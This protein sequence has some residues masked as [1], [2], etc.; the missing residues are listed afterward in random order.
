MGNVHGRQLENTDTTFHQGLI[1]TQG[2]PK[3]T[4]LICGATTDI[5]VIA[6]L[7]VLPL[8]ESATVRR[9]GLLKRMLDSKSA[10]LLG[11]IITSWD[12]QRRWA[13]KINKDL[14]I[15]LAL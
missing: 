14:Q 12:Q 9:L 13:T 5:G 1:I 7:S 6:D 3:Y 10:W 15:F 2:E 4:M 11:L 8:Q